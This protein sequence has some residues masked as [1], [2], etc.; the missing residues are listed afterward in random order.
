M[1]IVFMGTSDFA[2]EIL[3]AVFSAG[4]SVPLAVTRPD[5]PGNRG[6]IRISPVKE[7]ALSHDI[8]LIQPEILSR[9]P[10][11]KELLRSLDP[12]LIVVASYGQILKKD[13]LE[14][15]KSGCINVHA[16]LLPDFRGA[17]PVQHAILRGDEYAGVTVMLMEEE[18][19]AG[20]V[21]SQAKIPAAG[22]NFLTLEHELA[23]LG[24]ELLIRT[25]PEI[26]DGTAVFTEQDSAAATYAGQIRK[27]DGLMDFSLSAA[28]LERM[29]LAFDPWP[30]TFT[31]AV[32]GK[33][34]SV[35]LKILNAAAL[36]ASPGAGGITEGPDNVNEGVPSDTHSCAEVN[37]IYKRQVPVSKEAEFLPGTVI[38]AGDYGIDVMTGDGILRITELQAPGRKR[39]PAADFLRGNPFRAGDR[40][41]TAGGAF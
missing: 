36:P 19:D 11:A 38:G 34:G 35:R 29:I 23:R 14:I 32:R 37:G 2:E 26:E 33:G 20:P 13:V 41:G 16:S 28:E 18:L 1:N 9:D 4:Y 12:D 21:I 3:R 30:G 8:P 22:K 40:F 5:R 24:G 17:S 10:E 7:F 15:P 27:K 39:L 31:D 6:R 25:I